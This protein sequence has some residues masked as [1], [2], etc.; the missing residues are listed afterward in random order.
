MAIRIIQAYSD[1]DEMYNVP[2]ELG[3]RRELVMR[4]KSNSQ[5]AGIGPANDVYYYSPAGLKM[6]SMKDVQRWMDRFGAGK[7]TLANF[8]FK[9]RMTGVDHNCHCEIKRTARPYNR[10]NNVR[11]S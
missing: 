10:K 2:F 9:R 4:R 7:L 1:A 3:W 5:T 11:R 6:R 8:T